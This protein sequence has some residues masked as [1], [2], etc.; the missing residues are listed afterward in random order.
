MRETAPGI[1][2]GGIPPRP[3][4]RSIQTPTLGSR[5]IS[6]CAH[7]LIGAIQYPATVML[8]SWDPSGASPFR[9]APR[10]YGVSDSLSAWINVNLATAGDSAHVTVNSAF[11]GAEFLFRW[12]QNSYSVSPVLTPG[13][14]WQNDFEARI[15]RIGMKLKRAVNPL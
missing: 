2:P 3:A 12:G 13:R 11:I 14:L 10:S 6:R 9:F 7:T 15:P 4:Q 8:W 1:F 5:P